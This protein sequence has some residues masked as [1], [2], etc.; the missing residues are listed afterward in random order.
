MILAI[1]TATRLISVALH[2]GDSVV[3]ECTWRTANHHTVELSPALD[4]LFVR[5]GVCPANL[6]ALAVCLGPGSYTGL[7]IGMS[8]AKGLSLA[9]VPSLPIV[10]IPTLDIVAAAQPRQ[11][12]LLYAVIQAGRGRINVGVYNWQ[13]GIWQ[14]AGSPYIATWTELASQINLPAQLAGEIDARG[15]E[16]VRAVSDQISIASPAQGLRR[17]SYLA[18]L[19]YLKLKAG[20]NVAPD[21]L[22]PIYPA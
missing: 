22:A 21:A 14:A 12:D 13:E 11:A 1:D 16:A 19:A 4:D 5:S 8:L 18:E 6:A 7:R 9:A 3:A 2:D 20:Y 17:A 15:K 10:G